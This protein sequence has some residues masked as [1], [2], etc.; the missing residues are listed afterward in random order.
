MEFCKTPIER[1]IRVR[2]QWRNLSNVHLTALQ[3]EAEFVKA[4]TGL[5]KVG[6]PL[7]KREKFLG[8]VEKVTAKTGEEIRRDRRQ[9]EENGGSVIRLAETWEE[10]HEVLVELEGIRSGTKKTN[11]TS[12][13]MVAV[14]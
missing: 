3:F 1:Q 10:A 7:S 13:Y 5:E 4:I 2:E 8:Y 6:L 14:E 12:S 9:Y 11:I